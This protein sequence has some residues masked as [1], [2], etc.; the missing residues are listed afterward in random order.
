MDLSAE[1]LDS[2]SQCFRKKT[3]RWLMAD[4]YAQL[5]RHENPALM[6]IYDTVTPKGMKTQFI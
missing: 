1:T 3:K 5:N 4:K 2:L 6:D